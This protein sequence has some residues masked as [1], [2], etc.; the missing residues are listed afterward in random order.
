MLHDYSMHTC[1][2]LRAHGSHADVDLVSGQC[3]AVSDPHNLDWAKD[4]WLP[5]VSNI[6]VDWI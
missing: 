2:L 1:W 5:E 4:L 6:S 3:A